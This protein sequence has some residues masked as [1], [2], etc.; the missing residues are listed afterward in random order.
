MHDTTMNALHWELMFEFEEMEKTIMSP[1][2]LLERYIIVPN[3]QDVTQE[4][5]SLIRR[6]GVMTLVSKRK[7]RTIDGVYQCLLACVH[8]EML[9]D[10]FDEYRSRTPEQRGNPDRDREERQK[11]MMEQQQKRGS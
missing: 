9:Q 2:L 4:F 10:T 3:A 5:I 8:S 7:K 11:I 1:Q 6:T